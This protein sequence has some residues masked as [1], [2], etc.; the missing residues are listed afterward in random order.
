MTAAVTLAEAIKIAMTAPVT[1]VKQQDESWVVAF[2]MPEKWTKETLPKP[3]N[4]EVTIREVTGEFL[5]AIRFREGLMRRNEVIIPVASMQ[6][7]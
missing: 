5:A 7:K 1:Q 6:A 4:P 3:N 2:V